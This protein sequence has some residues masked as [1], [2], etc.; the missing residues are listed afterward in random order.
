MYR[1]K[2]FQNMPDFNDGFKQNNE[3]HKHNARNFT[4]VPVLLQT[5]V[6]NQMDFLWKKP[7][8]SIE[9]QLILKQ[10]HQPARKYANDPPVN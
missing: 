7:S 9:I 1:V 4:N 8:Q 5:F 3:L 10:I 2:Y 6:L